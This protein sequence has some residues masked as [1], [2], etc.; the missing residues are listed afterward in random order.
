MTFKGGLG[1]R[2]F[3]QRVEPRATEDSAAARSKVG[4]VHSDALRVQLA[5]RLEDQ[6][7]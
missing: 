1:K 7:S 4:L 3:Q 2:T 5:S 6:I